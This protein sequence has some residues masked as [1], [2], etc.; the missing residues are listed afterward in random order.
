VK[1]SIANLDSF[2]LEAPN[3]LG[4]ALSHSV[5]PPAGPKPGVDSIWGDDIECFKPRLCNIVGTPGDPIGSVF[6]DSLLAAPVFRLSKLGFFLPVNAGGFMKDGDDGSEVWKVSTLEFR[7]N[8]RLLGFFGFRGDGEVIGLSSLNGSLI[9]LVST[10]FRLWNESKP[11]VDPENEDN[12]TRVIGDSGEELGEGSDKED[13]STVDIV[14]VGDES[15]E[16]DACVDVLSRCWC[17]WMR[18]LSLSYSGCGWVW[19]GRCW[20]RYELVGNFVGASTPEASIKFASMSY[21]DAKEGI[22]FS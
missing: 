20:L 16:S 12:G 4:R 7:F 21:T 19:K 15:V 14:V 2:S 3:G 17:E 11:K 10:I 13:E 5:I 22:W 8:A 18:E 1:V 9:G 6:N